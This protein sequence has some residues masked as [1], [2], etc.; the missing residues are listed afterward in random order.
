MDGLFVGLQVAADRL[1][2]EVLIY[3]PDDGVYFLAG[4]S[5]TA[6]GQPAP[7]ILISLVRVSYPDGLYPLWKSRQPASDDLQ[8]GWEV[9]R[10][11]KVCSPEGTKP[12]RSCQE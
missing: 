9:V 8:V 2:G 4:K 10:R 1:F 5:V 3:K 12:S 7:H 6:T 11:G